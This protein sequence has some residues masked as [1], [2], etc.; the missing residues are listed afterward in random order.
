MRWG[1]KKA[2]IFSARFLA[3][4]F[5]SLYPLLLLIQ[6][7]NPK[8]YHRDILPIP[9]VSHS[10]LVSSFKQNWI[11]NEMESINILTGDS[12]G[13]LKWW[14]EMA[15]ICLWEHLGSPMDFVQTERFPML[16]GFSSQFSFIPLVLSPSRL[17]CRIWFGRFSISIWFQNI[18]ALREALRLPIWLKGKCKWPSKTRSYLGWLNWAFSFIH[19]LQQIE[20]FFN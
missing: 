9:R 7:F 10:T 17:F 18:R 1:R 8:K 12:R 13:M 2:N 20:N 19:Q 3:P 14:N 11:E 16:E 5:S 6:H 15:R 4:F